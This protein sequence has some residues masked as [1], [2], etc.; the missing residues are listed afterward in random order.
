M[1]KIGDQFLDPGFEETICSR[2]RAEH[3]KALLDA[4]PGQLREVV[5]L[6]VVEGLSQEGAAAA[7]GM[8]RY[9]LRVL[10]RRGQ[11]VLRALVEPEDGRQ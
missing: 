5:Q 3:L 11:A 2:L 10:Y 9:R 4:L 7:L 8:S 1:E 6:V